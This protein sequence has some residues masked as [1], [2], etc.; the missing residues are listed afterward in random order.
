MWSPRNFS[1]NLKP[2]DGKCLSASCGFRGNVATQEVDDKIVNVQQ[3]MSNVFVGISN[4]I[5]SS[6]ITVLPENNTA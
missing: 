2:E 1:A 3:K 6:I 4:N 5:E